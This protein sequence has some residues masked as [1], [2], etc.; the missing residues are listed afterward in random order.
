[1]AEDERIAAGRRRNLLVIA[2]GVVV[3][4]ILLT[5]LFR[6]CGIVAKRSAMDKY[7]VIYRN[8]DLKDAAK[9]I[10]CSNRP[11]YLFAHIG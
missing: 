4:T 10:A 7:T 6:S 1:M 2:V 3:A 9:S 8:L 5:F 11:V